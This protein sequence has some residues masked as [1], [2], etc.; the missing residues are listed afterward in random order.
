MFS[1]LA[2]E[3]SIK[4][5]LLPTSLGLVVGSSSVSKAF[6]QPS[7]SQL[8]RLCYLCNNASWEILQPACTDLFPLV[9]RKETDYSILSRG[10]LEP[11][12]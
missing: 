9:E 12:V 11:F 6:I 10:S 5:P 7:R 8:P 2:G 3:V 4:A 1:S